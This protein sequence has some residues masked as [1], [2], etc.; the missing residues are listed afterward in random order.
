MAN[1]IGQ[2]VSGNLVYVDRGAHDKRVV[3]AVGPD[4]VHYEFLPWNHNVQDEDATG[5]DPE[6]FFTTVVEVGAGTSE[7]DRSNTVGILAQMVTA[8]NDNDGI[9]LQLTGEIFE[10]TSNQGLVYFGIE[11]DIDDVDTS[12]ILAG[13][14][15]EDT[16]LLGG[17]SDGVYLESLDGATTS[18]GVTEKNSTETTSAASIA[19][20]SDNT[21][22]FLEFYFDGT[23]VYFYVDGAESA[24]IHTANIP[25]DEALTFSMEFLAGS[26][27]AST[28][29]I[30]QARAIMIGRT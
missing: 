9:S 6:G 22:H 20:L 27:A 30:R 11:V 2:R 3:H 10:F 12:D 14:C 26:A 18:F 16:A 28:C 29:D 7:L 5:T 13:L 24:T 1:V 23:S 17:L 25:D 4:V 15:I 8:A 19:T 21:F